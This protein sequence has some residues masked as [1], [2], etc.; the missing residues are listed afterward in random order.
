MTGTI[1]PREMAAADKSAEGLQICR[2]V[3]LDAKSILF[4]SQADISAFTSS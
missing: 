1:D 3:M 4:P 2:R